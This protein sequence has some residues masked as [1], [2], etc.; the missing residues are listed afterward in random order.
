MSSKKFLE[1]QGYKNIK[2]RILISM[3]ILIIV[4]VSAIIY[5]FFFYTKYCPDEVCFSESLKDC[6]KVSW[7]R[8]G[9]NAAWS[10][11]II[12]EKNQQECNIKVK[13]LKIKKGSSENEKLINKEMICRFNKKD[14][15]FPENDISKCS[16]ILKEEMQEII[17]Q[18][19]HNYLLENL[20]EIQEEFK[21]F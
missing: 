17:I 20:G 2:K 13:L 7:T 21:E 14:D 5:F 11:T 4:I 9:K 6:K 19:M 12:N 10:Y 15:A 1:S 8:E 16:G 18:N 3:I